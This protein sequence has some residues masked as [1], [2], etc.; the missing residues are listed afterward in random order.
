MYTGSG[1]RGAEGVEAEEELILVSRGRW[2]VDFVSRQQLRN[3]CATMRGWGSFG[4]QMRACMHIAW[5]DRSQLTV[6]LNDL[7]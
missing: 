6:S 2:A 3:L 7:S 5:G 1:G 4:M